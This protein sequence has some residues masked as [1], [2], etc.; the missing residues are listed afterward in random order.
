MIYIFFCKFV[1]VIKNYTIYDIISLLML[2]N[3]DDVCSGNNP[4]GSRYVA[5]TTGHFQDRNIIVFGSDMAGVRNP[6]THSFSTWPV[7]RLEAD[8]FPINIRFRVRKDKP[9]D[10]PGESRLHKST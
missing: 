2:S 10:K 5:H 4:R 9:S 7:R 3:D 1:N 6:I 8:I